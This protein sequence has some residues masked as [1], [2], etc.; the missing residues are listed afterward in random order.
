MTS[1]PQPGPGRRELALAFGS[2]ADVYDSVRPGYPDD[3]IDWLLPPDAR[4]VLDLGAGTGKL[5]GLL[6]ARGLD[7]T[8][9]DPS[10]PMLAQLQRR[11][12]GVS[13]VIGSGESIPLPDASLDACLVAQAWH[14]FDPVVASAE[15][16]RVLAPGGRLGLVWNIMDERTPWVAGFLARINRDDA[17]STEVNRNE[18][19][20][21][22]RISAPFGAAEHFET[23]W[24]TTM[25]P[26]DLVRLASSRSYVHTMPPE[27]RSRLLDEVLDYAHG[28]AEADGTLRLGYLTRCWRASR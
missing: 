6:A 19:I 9:V 27:L 17:S 2:V 10:E 28:A 23:S 20:A 12:P 15:T 21:R 25:T 22:P 8:A 3:A 24:T 11:H 26:G 18:R 14:W 4:R 7:V 13:T 1:T 16:G 5:S